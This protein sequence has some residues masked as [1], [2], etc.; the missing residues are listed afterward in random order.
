MNELDRKTSQVIKERMEA[1]SEAMVTRQYE[2]QPE[3]W[4]PFGGYPFNVSPTL[5]QQLGADGFARNAQESVA[6]AGRLVTN[7]N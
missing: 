1:L 5:W 2:L 4:Q 6:V 7:G 3:I